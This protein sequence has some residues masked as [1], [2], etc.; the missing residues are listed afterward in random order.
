[1]LQQYT[2]RFWARPSYSLPEKY[3]VGE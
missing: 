1:V 3:K 2:A